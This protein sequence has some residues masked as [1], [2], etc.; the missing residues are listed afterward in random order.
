MHLDVVV[1]WYLCDLVPFHHLQKGLCCCVTHELCFAI[2][3][4][5]PALVLLSISCSCCYSSGVC[6]CVVFVSRGFAELFS[7]WVCVLQCSK[8]PLSVSL[9]AHLCSWKLGVIVCESLVCVYVLLNGEKTNDE[10]WP[11]LVS[12]VRD[13]M[14]Y[15]CTFCRLVALFVIE[16]FRVC[17]VYCEWWFG[18]LCV[19]ARVSQVYSECPKC[20]V[21][22]V[23]WIQ[24]MWS[25]TNV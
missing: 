7:V 1:M 25:N 10:G 23:P 5:A 2:Y 4:E 16:T 17:C 13:H 20:T 8:T 6:V 24:T 19:C 15:L 21:P 3:V 14:V 11:S 12:L 18:V 22:C 9:H